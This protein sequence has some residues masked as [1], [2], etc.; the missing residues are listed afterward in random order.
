[1]RIPLSIT[2]GLKPIE[3]TGLV[4]SS[5]GGEFINAKFAKKHAFSL[6]PLLE[7]LSIFNTDGTRNWRG[8]VTHEAVIALRLLDGTI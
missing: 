2:T 5:A 4:D 7:L 8:D 6:E 3:T 1:M